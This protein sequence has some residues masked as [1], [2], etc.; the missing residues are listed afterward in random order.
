[1]LAE[2][3]PKCHEGQLLRAVGPNDVTALEMQQLT[4]GG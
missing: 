2:Q 3:I 1:M 4:L